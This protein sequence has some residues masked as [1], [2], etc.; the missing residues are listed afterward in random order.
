MT[1][2]Q[3]YFEDKPLPPIPEAMT[4]SEIE[5]PVSR[6]GGMDSRAL[7]RARAR[8]RRMSA[9]TLAQDDAEITEQQRFGHRWNTRDK[10]VVGFFESVGDNELGETSPEKFLGFINYAGTAADLIG[11][12]AS[13]DRIEAGE[14]TREDFDK[15]FKFLEYQARPRD[16]ASTAGTIVG[17]MPAFMQE[18]V[19]AVG[20]GGMSA[21]AS[22]SL[23]AAGIGGKI[24]AKAV[25]TGIARGLIGTGKHGLYSVG[26]G[27]FARSTA[28]RVAKNKLGK[29]AVAGG[30]WVVNRSAQALGAGA[31]VTGTREGVSRGIG[32]AIDLATEGTFLGENFRSAGRLGNAAMTRYFHEKYNLHPSEFGLDIT[33]NDGVAFIDFV[34]QDLVDSIIEDVSEQLGKPV[35]EVVTALGQGAKLLML[36]GAIKAAGD[37]PE[38]A[39][40]VMSRYATMGKIQQGMSAAGVENPFIE[41]AEEVIGTEA[42]QAFGDNVEGYEAWRNARRDFYEAE[43]LKGVVAGLLA[44]GYGMQGVGYAGAK[45][46][47]GFGL[48]DPNKQTFDSTLELGRAAMRVG[49]D[50]AA[51]AAMRDDAQQYDENGQPPASAQFLFNQGQVGPNQILAAR[52][53]ELERLALEK[54]GIDPAGATLE[55]RSR[56]LIPLVEEHD[57]LLADYEAALKS[58][59][60]AA[61]DAEAERLRMTGDL[62]VEGT[63]EV[64]GGTPEAEEV[65]QQ[66]EV[67]APQAEVVSETETEVI[68]TVEEPEVDV[69]STQLY[70]LDETQDSNK[71]LTVE[72]NG[73]EVVLERTF[74]LTDEANQRTRS[75]YNAKR[76]QEAA[77][78]SL[79]GAR[80]VL[81]RPGKAQPAVVPYDELTGYQQQ[82][83][84]LAQRGGKSIAFVKGLGQPA[85]YDK[86][87]GVVLFDIN[88]HK[89][90]VSTL[91][92][93]GSVLEEPLSPIQALDSHVLHEGSHR[94]LPEQEPL[95]RTAVNLLAQLQDMLMPGVRVKNEAKYTAAYKQSTGE[96]LDADQ[97][98]EEG[99]AV[100]MQALVPYFGALAR[101][102]DARAFERIMSTPDGRGLMRRLV[103]GFKNALSFLPMVG[104]RLAY[105]DPRVKAIEVSMS[106]LDNLNLTEEQIVGQSALTQAFMESWVGA[107]TN[108]D[109]NEASLIAWR[110]ARERKALRARQRKRIKDL[111]EEL[112]GLRKEAAREQRRETRELDAG[113]AETGAEVDAEI[114]AER[115]RDQE[116]IAALEEELERRKAKLAAKQ[117]PKAQPKPQAQAKPQAEAKPKAKAQAKPA[118]APAPAAPAPA[119]APVAAEPTPAP[120]PV[121][122]PAPEPAAQQPKAKPKAKPKVE[123]AEPQTPPAMKA[124]R[125]ELAEV[126]RERK[127]MRDI[128]AKRALTDDERA[129]L[130]TLNERRQELKKALEED[131]VQRGVK[132]PKAPKPVKKA[133][134]KAKPPAEPKAEAKPKED[135]S[136]KG[137]VDTTGIT[138]REVVDGPILKTLRKANIMLFVGKGYTFA[139]EREQEKLD[140]MERGTEGYREQR[141]LVN[142]L[143][144]EFETQKR[145]AARKKAKPTAAEK[146]TALEESREPA[147]VEMEPATSLTREE[148]AK[149]AWPDLV[150]LAKRSGLAVGRAGATRGALIDQLVNAKLPVPPTKT[151]GGELLRRTKAQQR[152]VNE[153]RNAIRNTQMEIDRIEKQPEVVRK[154][155][156][157]KRL[158]DLRATLAAQEHRLAEIERGIPPENVPKVEP[159]KAEPKAKK[160]E[161]ARPK[162]ETAP[163]LTVDQQRI[164]DE[165]VEAQVVEAVEEAVAPE[166]EPVAEPA[167]EAA[168]AA[169]TEAQPTKAKTRAQRRK[170][171]KQ[172]VGEDANKA[173]AKAQKE[174]ARVLAE[175]MGIRVEEVEMQDALDRAKQILRERIPYKE[176]SEFDKAIMEMLFPVGE[177]ATPIRVAFATAALR[178]MAYAELDAEMDAQ[179]IPYDIY[180][181][182]GKKGN[183]IPRFYPTRTNLLADVIRDAPS[184]LEVALERL[185]SKPQRE[186]ARKMHQEWWAREK[187][188]RLA[189]DA[190]KRELYLENK[191]RKESGRT[192]LY[193]DAQGLFDILRE[194]FPQEPRP[195]AKEIA[196]EPT[197]AERRQARK[198]G[199]ANSRVPATQPLSFEWWSNA[200]E[201]LRGYLGDMLSHPLMKSKKRKVTTGKPAPVAT[202]ADMLWKDLTVEEQNKI[203]SGWTAV[204]ATSV[205]ESRL[206][207]AELD[208]W[209][210]P[211]DEIWQELHDPELSEKKKQGFAFNLTLDPGTGSS[212]GVEADVVAAELDA[213]LQA[214]LHT[215]PLALNRNGAIRPE[216]HDVLRDF[217]AEYQF[218]VQGY[219][220]G[221]EP[222]LNNIASF[223]QMRERMPRPAGGRS[224]ANLDTNDAIA[225]QGRTIKEAVD[226]D[227]GL[228]GAVAINAWRDYAKARS[229]LT[230]RDINTVARTVNKAFIEFHVQAERRIMAATAVNAVA[231][232]TPGYMSKQNLDS[233]RTIIDLSTASH[234]KIAVANLMPHLLN[235]KPIAEL[236]NEAYLAQVQD[237]RNVLSDPGGTPIM[238]MHTSASAFWEYDLKQQDPYIMVSPDGLLQERLRPW[239]ESKMLERGSPMLETYWNYVLYDK[240]FDGARDA[241][242]LIDH[243]PSKTG[244]LADQI[245]L[246]GAA[247]E[248][249]RGLDQGMPEVENRFAYMQTKGA[250]TINGERVTDPLDPRVME[251]L[252]EELQYTTLVIENPYMQPGDSLATMPEELRNRAIGWMSGQVENHMTGN[253]KF[254]RPTGIADEVDRAGMVLNAPNNWTGVELPPVQKAIRA[255]GFDAFAVSERLSSQDGDA[256]AQ[257]VAVFSA[258]Q[259]VPVFHGQDTDG[260]NARFMY[261]LA[262]SFDSGV[263]GV[264]YGFRQRVNG[265]RGEVHVRGM[266]EI[267]DR[268]MVLGGAMRTTPGGAFAYFPEMPEFDEADIPAVAKQVI[269]HAA[270]EGVADIVVDDI[271]MAE[272]LAQQLGSDFE[273]I[274]DG[275]QAVAVFPAKIRSLGNRYA[276]GA[277]KAVREVD[278]HI[279]GYRLWEDNDDRFA[280]GLFP[281][282]GADSEVNEARMVYEAAYDHFQS[283]FESNKADNDYYWSRFEERLLE[284]R[285]KNIKPGVWVRETMAAIYHRVDLENMQIETG[286]SMEAHVDEYRAKAKKNGNPWNAQQ[287]RVI[288]TALDLPPG[289]EKL[290][291]EGAYRNELLGRDLKARNLI[292]NPR[293]FYAPRI[294]TRDKVTL[295]AQNVIS[296]SGAESD[297]TR[298]GGRFKTGLG[299]RAK[300][301]QYESAL[302]GWARG[303]QLINSNFAAISKR[304][305]ADALEMT[306]NTFF[307]NVL[308]RTGIAH[309]G[310]KDV[311]D[312]YVPLG[313]NA[314]ALRDIYI[315]EQFKTEVFNRTNRLDWSGTGWSQFQKGLYFLNSKTKASMLFTSLFHHGAFNRS[316]FF[317]IPGLFKGV[318]GLTFEAPRVMFGAGMAALPFVGEGAKK[319]GERIMM[320][321]PSVRAGAEHI[322]MNHPDFAKLKANGLT[323]SMGL[324]YEQAM[325]GEELWKFTF[326]EDMAVGLGKMFGKAGVP[327]AADVGLAVAN[328]MADYRNRANHLLFTKLGSSLKV[329]AALLN[330]R[331]ELEK[332]AQKISDGLLTT[333]DIAF[334]VA[335]K[336]NADFGG[337]NLHRGG[338]ILGGKPR[339]AASEKNNRILFLATDWTESNF[340]TLINQS[341]FLQR[342]LG[343][344]YS[345]LGK[346]KEEAIRNVR[347]SMYRSLMLNAMV[348]SQII[349]VMWNALMAGLDDEKTIADHYIDTLK[350][351]G[352]ARLNVLN[353][354][355]TLLANAMDDYLH[356]LFGKEKPHHPDSRV[357][358]SVLGHFLDGGKWLT[359]MFASILNPIER[360]DLFGPLKAKAG[361]V[362]RLGLGFLSGTDWK[363]QSYKQTLV[364][365]NY[366]NKDAIMIP[367]LDGG[368]QFTGLKKWEFNPG[369]SLDPRKLP[370]LAADMAIGTMPIASQSFLHMLAGE[371]SVFDFIG[372]TFGLHMTR[373]Y[374]ERDFVERDKAYFLDFD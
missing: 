194:E 183:R 327:G 46:A 74:Q 78:A 8:V 263:D 98:K 354:D 369:G 264:G 164:V 249:S 30:S 250:L 185:D 115:A 4:P 200:P 140:A 165:L 360:S 81:R 146:L 48:T 199:E 303:Q 36:K 286:V 93:D 255:A 76:N 274:G 345:Y 118:P 11:L 150:S 166:P 86:A 16:W 59:D 171:V 38:A 307:R 276:I 180:G 67:I 190:R 128:K 254:D 270:M 261:N 129:T 105:A 273:D 121:A 65:T 357:Y 219:L 288:A 245:V 87:N 149:L 60:P 266:F 131:L 63:Q 230:Q 51:L 25:L 279:T 71:P 179:S 82:M 37:S 322:A 290:M 167:A 367:D 203:A 133:E 176:Q 247:V 73:Q 336:I 139:I 204:V 144:N 339:S 260:T 91:A 161:D 29:Y 371:D 145:A 196:A 158:R 208:T 243:L 231:A 347:A 70:D 209:L 173:L 229:E 123:A 94:N 251:R 66:P 325:A 201:S 137:P 193:T 218:G 227:L 222:M 159:R 295:Q 148:L 238:T 89:K 17:E 240:M 236:G 136:K 228:L 301:R 221:L 15:L 143:K 358:F 206:T 248:A 297:P 163:G 53:F 275:R 112:S 104:K 202:F 298:A 370:A 280:F 83:V 160:P 207:T 326:I 170:Q 27:E 109:A 147:P 45:F 152:A 113:V 291:R 349:T 319:W 259:L 343:K 362:P 85:V 72:I 88:L 19:A 69:E 239:F 216:A 61:L 234:G 344:D 281:H 287:E 284:L 157:V 300:A 341:K 162:V 52:R 308:L 366:F 39:R 10:S 272:E 90:S 205:T 182:K 130:A 189:R 132:D 101:Q 56:V 43:N 316:Y 268:A 353:P 6:P 302:V 320:E 134:P 124:A 317:S 12:K 335:G 187:Q 175:R 232:L 351:R 2:T 311:P 332:N 340:T 315:L 68:D 99:V 197:R 368:Y 97:A 116:E 372:D 267:G 293:A 314:P 323:V 330:Y 7:E 321:S 269:H 213:E 108:L 241:S 282:V 258:D 191:K 57:R 34:P 278:E 237:G 331:H 373:T 102:N 28:E 154:K 195:W 306:S 168:P 77:Q 328:S 342:K 277:A 226:R 138:D 127:A 256:Y 352:K 359:D 178:S 47:E 324:Q 22:A 141:K 95:R 210:R 117:Q 41:F 54:A 244:N 75:E 126:N 299:G 350:L 92:P 26:L 212:I 181:L 14:G 252:D 114:E 364:S 186:A 135:K 312:G 169:E 44:G 296:L 235:G 374:P 58:S 318:T 292:Q 220:R 225:D 334:E 31:I 13:S 62:V 192:P 153:Q 55:D 49:D 233:L 262:Q 106:A 9:A 142:Q 304:V 271:A 3:P 184:Y 337:R 64:E 214:L 211:L 313:S 21:G 174:A 333:D 100:T 198:A 285:P 155:G 33:K 310:H 224:I 151:K 20:T 80:S 217:L 365:D 246:V 361:F 215:V 32:G 42:R 96:D 103:D 172:L 253:H 125:E 111:T 40:K 265:P 79:E 329:R 18:T 24:G 309:E 120:E 110:E 119:P 188:R 363:G 346:T 348:R 107:G 177:A 289:V 355:V 305:H 294:W 356:D 242:E 35:G 50:A 338:Q 283:R 84:H 5:E 23:R 156:V 122:E 223:E 257:S 1:D